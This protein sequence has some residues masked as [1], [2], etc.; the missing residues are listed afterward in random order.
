MLRM[1][2]SE[3]NS[4]MFQGRVADQVNIGILSVPNSV[5]AIMF[6]CANYINSACLK[7]P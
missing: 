6:I 7:I 1:L 4:L 2:P 5:R 3:I